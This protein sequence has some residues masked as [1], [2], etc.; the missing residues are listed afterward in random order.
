[1]AD[2]DRIKAL[3]GGMV[4][5]YGVAIGDALYKGDAPTEDLL[6]LRQQTRETLA[7]FG[8]LHSAL[9]DIEKELSKRGAEAK[10]GPVTDHHFYVRISGFLMGDAKKSEIENKIGELIAEAMATV[11]TGGVGKI[12]PFSSINS[13]GADVLGAKGIGGGGTMGLVY[14]E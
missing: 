1:M 6:K 5:L 4:Q 11:D 14:R 9:N 3:P 13:Y 12:T 7:Q 2:S 8:D 10:D